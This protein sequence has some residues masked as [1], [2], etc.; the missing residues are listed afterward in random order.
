MT[1][2]TAQGLDERHERIS[3]L[4]DA[5]GDFHNLAEELSADPPCYSEIISCVDE[6]IKTLTE[7]RTHLEKIER[8][9]ADAEGSHS[10][11]GSDPA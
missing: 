11:T 3:V 10:H 5:M 9:A 2:N 6:L 1:D 8:E 7:A 4:L